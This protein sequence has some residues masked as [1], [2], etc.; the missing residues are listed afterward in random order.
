MAA[1]GRVQVQLAAAQRE[2][3]TLMDDVRASPTLALL[4]R[5]DVQASVGRSRE[6]LHQL[7]AALT[8]IRERARTS[9][10]EPNLRA[11]AAS[12]ARLQASLAALDSVMRLQGGT[13]DRLLRDSA[14]VR[15]IG[16]AR[17][18]LDSLIA[19]AKRNPLRYVF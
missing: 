15:A 13:A 17:A 19:D 14:L 6:T 12:A 16:A 2:Y 4:N 10:A 3:G 7:T 1:F 8:R 18:E 5:G 11:A 9:G